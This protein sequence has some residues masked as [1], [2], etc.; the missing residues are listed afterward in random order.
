MVRRGYRHRSAAIKIS[1]LRADKSQDG[2]WDVSRDGRADGNRQGSRSHDGVCAAHRPAPR[3]R[4]APAIPWT[5]AFAV[6]NF[7]E[8]HRQK[9]DSAQRDLALALIDQVHGVLGRYREDD[10][11]TGWLSGLSGEEGRSRPT[12]GGLRI[13]KPLPE[14]RPGEPYDDRVE[15]APLGLE[16]EAFWL[17][18]R[19]RQ[20]ETWADHRDI[21]EV[22]L[23]TSIA[24]KTF[25][26]I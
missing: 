13:G 20:N 12:A 26:S 18:Q 6:C 17:D 2:A 15:W 14:R 3:Q 8:L 25:L 22:M 10:A 4:P 1:V 19:H 23:A 11:R 9:D 7:L 24:P 16:I 5:D 21:N